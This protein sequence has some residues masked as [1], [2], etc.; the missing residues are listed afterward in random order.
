MTYVIRIPICGL[1]KDSAH[2]VASKFTA[3]HQAAS[4][5][6]TVMRTIKQ[7]QQQQQQQQQHT[8]THKSF[9]RKYMPI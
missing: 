6:L 1:F 7:Q 5:S 2:Y 3:S 8:H 4:L 9:V